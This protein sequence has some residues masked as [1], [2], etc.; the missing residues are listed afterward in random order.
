[1]IRRRGGQLV[2]FW[3]ELAARLPWLPPVLPLDVLESA[4]L[5]RLT[6]PREGL[7]QCVL[8]QLLAPLKPD[9]YF[10]VVTS[11]VHVGG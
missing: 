1:M 11:R 2:V 9:D 4:R 10:V 6:R 3:P 5:Q 8:A 7:P